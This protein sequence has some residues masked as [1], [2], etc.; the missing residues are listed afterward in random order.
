MLL[1][2]AIVV[3]NIPATRRV[4]DSIALPPLLHKLVRL[5]L[6]LM[7]LPSNPFTYLYPRMVRL[8][9]GRPSQK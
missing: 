1:E 3:E 7:P 5:I 9:R 2:M 4:P 6:T 8:H